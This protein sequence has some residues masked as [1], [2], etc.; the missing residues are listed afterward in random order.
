[1]LFGQALQYDEGVN[2]LSFTFVVFCRFLSSFVG[3]LFL[4]SC[5]AL[6]MD[7]REV[8]Q[9]KISYL[10]YVIK[11]LPRGWIGIHRGQEVAV[12]T[13]DPEDK[14]ITPGKYRRFCTKNKKGSYYKEKIESYIRA[15]NE[16]TKLMTEWRS[17]YRDEPEIINFPLDRTIVS[18]ISE[19]YYK[20]SLSN[21]NAAPI[22]YPISYK[23]QILRSK[24][25][26]MAI[27]LIEQL[28]FD[29]KTEIHICVGKNNMYP[30]VTFLVPY[31]QKAIGLEIDGM[32]EQ[33]DYCIKAQNR[34][35]NYLS[36]GFSDY[37]DIL[38]FRLSENNAFDAIALKTMIE[39]A[40]ALN[41]A[42]ILERMKYSV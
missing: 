21:Q 31:L 4:F 1:L 32:M 38:F 35:Y 8:L 15:N 16:L 12:V 34:Q 33:F 6:H 41:A 14:S 28:G 25:E 10:I 37:K 7:T 13:Y 42:E 40:I 29:W 3:K 20:A 5:Y 19:R 26:M 2:Y 30:D 24:N 9:L 39:R 23:G 36:S 18:G 11:N 22:K 17:V 27:Q